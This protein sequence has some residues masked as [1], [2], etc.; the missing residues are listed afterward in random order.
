M[1]HP[2]ADI[3]RLVRMLEPPGGSRD[4]V[5]DT[6]AANEIDDQFAIVHALLSETLTV[7]A[8]YAAPFHAEW[9]NTTGPDE[10]ME[11]SYR[12]IHRVLEK[13]PVNFT[14]RVLR[15]SAQYM[16][17]ADQAV[18]SDSASDL[19]SRAMTERDGPL[20]VMALGA[21]TNVA[22]A[23][24]MEPDIVGR[25]VVIPLGG[26]P[27]ET[28]SYA[29]MNFTE[30]VHAVRVLFDSGAP[31]VH[32]VGYVVSE[33]MRTTESEM[34]RYVQ[35]RGAI[36]DYLYDL[37]RDRIPSEPGRSKAIWD[38]AVGAWLIEPGWTASRLTPS[39]I[40]NEG[41]RY[42][43]DPNRHPVR[44]VTRVDRDAIFGDL[45]RKLDAHTA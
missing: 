27:Y 18:I 33:M 28:G 34:A 8:I 10:G 12:E 32:V 37:Y 24:L 22:S 17:A 4:V 41:L 31:V 9:T 2:P 14:G 15:G 6:D 23:I 44:V 30:D 16:S 38:L 20:Y 42:S 21:V 29:D 43:F 19:V 3:A 45:F 1:T 7:E 26:S 25:I 39:P 13:T 35:G 36:G 5:I 11:L 40:F